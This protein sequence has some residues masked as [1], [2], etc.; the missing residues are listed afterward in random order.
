MRICHVDD[1]PPGRAL[2]L[3]LSLPRGPLALLCVGTADGPRVYLNSCPHMGS[4]LNWRE[5]DFWDEDEVH[6]R[7][8]THGALFLPASGHCVAGPCAGQSLLAVPY[9]IDNLGNLVLSDP[10][11]LPAS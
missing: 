7:C 5:Q 1:L 3:S 2:G 11:A 9:H 8:A 6:L 4:T 10:D